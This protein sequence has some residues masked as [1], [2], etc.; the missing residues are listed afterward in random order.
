MLR[1]LGLILLLGSSLLSCGKGTGASGAGGALSGADAL[2]VQSFSYQNDPAV[3]SWTL[4]P[5]SLPNLEIQVCTAAG[6]CSGQLY[7]AC[8][9]SVCTVQ[10][11]DHQTE[12]SYSIKL[13]DNGGTVETF[14]VELCGMALGFAS[15]STFKIRASDQTRSGPWV[16]GSAANLGTQSWCNQSI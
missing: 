9:N 12:S 8:V 5:H 1:K 13:D 10:D 14:R 6:D 16:T 4:P 15:N 2:A 7:V 3:L 11:S